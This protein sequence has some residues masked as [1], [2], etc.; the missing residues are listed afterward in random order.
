MGSFKPFI[1]GTAFGAGVVFVAL[2]YHVIQSKDGFRV[3]PRTP[4]HSLGL[5][6]A[7]IRHWDADQWADR[8]ELVRALVADGSSDLVAGSVASG[9]LDSVSEDGGTLDQLRSFLNDSS[10]QSGSSDSL[11]DSPGLSIPTSSQTDSDFGSEFTVPFPGE[12]KRKT[13]ETA[14]RNGDK[15]SI[16]DVFS[17]SVDELAG[18]RNLTS[19]TSNAATDARPQTSSRSTMSSQQETELLEEMLFGDDEPTVREQ[20]SESAD[21]GG[22]GMFEDVTTSLENRAKQVLKKAK[23]GVQNEASQALNE[24]VG[25]AN[26]F[27]RDKARESLPDSVSGMFTEDLSRTSGN[28]NTDSNLPDA[29]KAIREG[30]DPFVD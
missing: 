16:D 7:D 17:A 1:F 21:Q 30:F 9:V 11:F 25:S 23:K 6:Y 2:Q 3:V 26:R 13:L 29:L 4:Q 5:A 12:A 27:I 24:G 19:S 8:P 22:F 10:S 28:S 20:S 14:Q 15:L 18:R